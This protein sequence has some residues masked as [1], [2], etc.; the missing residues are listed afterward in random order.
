MRV[1]GDIYETWYCVHY[2]QNFS[3]FTGAERV[4]IVFQLRRMHLI[5]LIR[6][7]WRETFPRLGYLKGTSQIT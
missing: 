3:V 1:T 2:N 4:L 6:L 7:L 5:L